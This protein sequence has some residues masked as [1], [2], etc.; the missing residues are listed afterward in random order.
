MSSEYKI[1]RDRVFSVLH[2]L[3]KEHEIYADAQMLIGGAETT[4]SLYKQ[5]VKKC[6]D[7]DWI[8]AIEKTI[9]ALDTVIRNPTVAIQDIEE[10]LPLELSR[11]I[12]D[13]SVKHL[14]QHTNLIM[15]IKD[16]DVIPQ[17]IMNVYRDETYL[18]YE[19]KFINT[20][21]ARLSAFVDKR[22][23]ALLGGRGLEQKYKF[24]YTTEFEHFATDDGGR[25][26]AM[27]EL[28]IHLTSPLEL[29]SDGNTEDLNARYQN[30]FDRINRLNLMITSYQS[31]VFAQK[32]GRAYIRPPVIRTNAI[33]KNKNMKECLKLW[34]FIEGFDK[35]GYSVQTGAE[36]QMP[37][38]DYVSDLYSTVSLQ[39][40]NFYNGVTEN[41]Y[42]RMLS[43]KNL[44]DMEA[45]FDTTV[46]DKEL[47]DYLVYDSE[48]RKL[49]P[50]SRLMSNRKKFSD[51]ERR[52]STAI[53]V[54]LK[55]D[56]ILTQR[57]LEEERRRK[58][59]EEERRRREEEEARLRAEEEA[60]RRAEEEARILAEAEARRIAEAE[61]ARKAAEEEAARKAAEEEAA[62]KAAEEEAAR[63][64]AEEEAARIAA[65]EEAARI[66][67]EQEAARRAAEEEA[68][69]IAAE[70]E[71]ARKAAEE[72]AARIA[73]E[74][75]AARRA[76]KLAA[77][78]AARLAA[79]EKA[80]LAAEEAERKKNLAD[81]VE[82]LE[83]IL[84]RE[85]EDMDMDRID[86]KDA[87][88][89]MPEDGIIKDYYPL[90]PYTRRQ[91]LD[92]PRKK[93]K[94]IKVNIGRMRNYRNAQ[95][96]LLALR[97]CNLPA[98]VVADQT[99]MLK[100]RA[101]ELRDVIPFTEKWQTVVDYHTV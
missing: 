96:R 77:L 28:N 66:A 7:T 45:E 95:R 51:D 21:L 33:L 14:A 36:V 100:K 26:S 47:E 65:E 98:D 73:A 20:L 90:C 31:S 74:Q 3:A 89:F 79:E 81:T 41:E 37:S 48:Y 6:I 72:E 46:A 43:K 55:V 85:D 39:Y 54:A 101:K 42:N 2:A 15:D 9:P 30:A 80:R 12:N 50:V 40:V 63:I 82:E 83:D 64:A 67:A 32:L 78:E 49:V 11:Y 60:R 38:T 58:A 27:I 10:I 4:A 94:Q 29:E 62:R 88:N 76:A 71:A 8:D 22:Y 44:Y 25:N 86:D 23:R 35:V 34:E 75:E 99:A 92:T 17:K 52:I 13:R 87:Q 5:S 57:R 24:H 59:E 18:T 1:F 93:K 91:Y 84:R 53:T 69:R 16:D 56:D 97:S 70:E 19:N 68:A 61:A